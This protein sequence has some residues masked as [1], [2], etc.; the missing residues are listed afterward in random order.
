MAA[1][2]SSRTDD[3]TAG[4]RR[5]KW[6]SAMPRS[7]PRPHP[8]FPNGQKSLAA[9]RGEFRRSTQHLSQCL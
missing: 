5:R 6:L 2:P 9:H 1:R 8:D 7:S 4:L 3:Y